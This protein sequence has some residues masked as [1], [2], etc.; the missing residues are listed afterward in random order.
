MQYFPYLLDIIK[1]GKYDP[2]FI[3]TC[4]DD[5]EN[6]AADYAKLYAQKVCD[7]SAW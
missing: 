5:F 1:D 4:E 6:I 3:F 7:P 2:S